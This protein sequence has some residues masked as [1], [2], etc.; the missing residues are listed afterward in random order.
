MIKSNAWVVAAA[1]LAAAALTARLGLW[2][3]D[4]AA[5]KVA[6]QQAIDLA[7]DMP[8]LRLPELPADA[9]GVKR[10]LH[11]RA[12]AEG[13]WIQE[14]TVLLDNRPLD[15][16][17]GFIVVTPLRL[18]DGRALAVQRGW[19]PRD[20]RDRTQV[21]PFDT[22]AGD[23]RIEGR[24]NARLSRWFDLGPGSPG[25]IRQNLELD[26]YGREF[27]LQLLP[28]ALLQEELPGEPTEG[29]VRR[30]PVPTT[31]VQMH[32]GYAFQWFALSAL[33]I[34]LYGWFG[35]IRPRRRSA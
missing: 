35:I 3:L 21:A 17:S 23:V 12:V 22:P 27:R 31:G 4:R 26:A 10:V 29:L 32:Y 20:G 15:G 34:V 11:R 13:R 6:V 25:P 5:Q 9:S 28:F 24:I 2:Q 33:V 16:R 19:L 30:W 1:A 8:A 18:A 14:A 7:R